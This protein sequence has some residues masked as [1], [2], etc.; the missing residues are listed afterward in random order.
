MFEW[1]FLCLIIRQ[2]VKFV[3]FIAVFHKK[4]VVNSKPKIMIEKKRSNEM[5]EDVRNEIKLIRIVNSMQKWYDL[6]C[7]RRFFFPTFLILRVCTCIKVGVLSSFFF[8]CCCCCCCCMGR[9]P[10]YSS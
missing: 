6:V 3:V 10:K 9:V 1:T 5:G 8:F 7:G 4:S 2:F